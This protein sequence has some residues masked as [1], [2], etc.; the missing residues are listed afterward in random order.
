MKVQRY[1]DRDGREIVRRTRED[2]DVRGPE[3][4]ERLE[5]A[6]LGAIA[7][8]DVGRLAELRAEYT[9]RS[10]GLWADERHGPRRGPWR[11]LASEA[12]ASTS[13]SHPSPAPALTAPA[14]APLRVEWIRVGRREIVR[15]AASTLARIEA[16]LAD[17]DDGRETGGWLYASRHSGE[18][19][20]ASGAGERARRTER[21]LVLDVAYREVFEATL[22]D[23]LGLAGD[24]HAHPGDGAERLGAPS[25]G[26]LRG[27]AAGLA[28]TEDRVGPRARYVGLVA[29]TSSSSRRD[30]RLPTLHAFVMRRDPVTRAIRCENAAIEEV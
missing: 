11:V 24:Y 29:T 9:M 25:E 23:D 17:C 16:E 19:V 13:H 5:E 3:E 18:I 27:W 7:A 12:P 26:D 15:I 1:R 30:W 28:A 4:A 20:V 8:G 10:G 22:S 14:R 6:I 21:D 2:D